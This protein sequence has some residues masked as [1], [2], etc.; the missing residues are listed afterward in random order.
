MDKLAFVES[1]QALTSQEDVLAVSREVNELRSKFEDFIIEEDRKFQIAQ[2]EARERGEEPEERQQD[3]VRQSFYDIFNEYR[4]RKN[5]AQR[6]K[7]DAEAIHLQQKRR[8]IERLKAVIQNEENIGAALASYKEIHEA[9]KVVG[10]IP[11]DKRQEVQ[12]E[13]SRLLEDFFYH[14]KIYRELREHD[15]HRNFQLKKD[16][17]TRIQALEN[18]PQIK[19]VE[20]ALKS[21]QNEW[22][23]CGPVNNDAWETLKTEYWEAVKATY[24]RIQ[25]FYDEKRHELA[26]NLASKQALV[27]KV[28][29]LIDTTYSSTKD[30]EDATKNL[31]VLQEE[32]K[33]IGF[34]PKKENEEVWKTFRALCD[35]FFAAKKSFFD[36][37][38]SQYDD[39]AAKKQEL[40]NQVE[41]L[42]TSTEWKA[43]GEKIIQLQKRWKEFGS[44]GQ[45]Q[46]Q[47]LW[48]EFRAACDFFFDAKQAFYANQDKELEGNLQLKLELIER[49]Q[50]LELPAERKH[51][52]D[53][54]KEL[55][56]EY[57]AI[58]FVPMKQKDEVYKAYKE[59]IEAHYK[60]LKLE[61]AEKERVQFQNRL[62]DLK[63]RP[64]AEKAIARER[65][66]M[67]EKISRLKA[68]I[69]QYEN[70]LG[71]FGRSKGADAMK[72][73]VENK[74]QS[75]H[76]KIEELK[77]KMKALTEEV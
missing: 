62:E 48:K 63:S 40:I 43:T 42:K 50:K 64:N 51:A 28:Q 74:I 39:I 67:A 17:I 49:I 47:K 56:N 31:L 77:Q 61:G 54:L 35:Q 69:L 72:K 25:A 52:L 12:S 23:E 8:L 15:L 53:L 44:A 4:E 1:L 22:D 32:W 76:R 66:D 65:A 59:A 3:P 57:S 60:V 18:L 33:H 34:G 24:T 6:A 14:L 19:D 70:N 45:R 13:Y 30:W 16:V 75:A 7:A 10:E 2:I 29:T 36:A 71:F 9:W 5:A 46:E 11:R 20:Q 68:D 27:D 21:L 73:E 37:I 38:R 58:G 55:A 26:A 41:N